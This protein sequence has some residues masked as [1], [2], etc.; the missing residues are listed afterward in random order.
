MLNNMQFSVRCERAMC[1]Q[2]YRASGQVLSSTVIV[3]VNLHNRC[4]AFGKFR[5]QDSLLEANF[6][7]LC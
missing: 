3:A 2:S 6:I 5:G 4:L 1:K 7:S